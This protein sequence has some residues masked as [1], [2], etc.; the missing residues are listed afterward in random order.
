M[1]RAPR[2]TSWRSRATGTVHACATVGA[3]LAMCLGG[4]VVCPTPASAGAAEDTALD[5]DQFESQILAIAN[6]HRKAAGLKPVRSVDPC[7]DRLSGEWAAHLA[8]TGEFEHRNQRRILRRCNLN[9]TGENLIRGTAFTPAAAVK[10]WLGSPGHRA[11]L[12]KPR[13]SL[14]GIGISIDA[15]GKI[16]GALNFGDV[17]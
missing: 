4:M 5:P 12:M 3:V 9:W 17:S 6:Q 2:R 14:A 13:A 1:P 16:V 11:V 7:L 10:S 15:E 8:A